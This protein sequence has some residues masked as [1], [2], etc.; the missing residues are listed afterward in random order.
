[1]KRV[2]CSAVCVLFLFS[3][4]PM[5][6]A[7]TNKTPAPQQGQTSAEF[8]KIVRPKAGISWKEKTMM[9]REIQKRAAARRNVLI[10]Q[11]EAQRLKVPKV[12][13]PKSRIEP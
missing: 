10:R 4:I 8:G 7:G 3:W 6:A 5:T 12:V 9:Q 11:A 13:P 1:M 2:F